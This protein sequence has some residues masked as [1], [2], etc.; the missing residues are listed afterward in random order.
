MDSELRQLLSQVFDAS[1]ESISESDDADSI[2]AWDSVHHLELIMALEQHYDIQ[3]D[4]DEIPN[5]R[6]V[7]D[8]VRVVTAAKG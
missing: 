2:A 3:I 6:T 7:A 8:I 1:P 5:I 4:T